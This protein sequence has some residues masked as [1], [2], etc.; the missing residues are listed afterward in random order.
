MGVAVRGRTRRRFWRRGLHLQDEKELGVPEL[1]EPDSLWLTPTDSRCHGC[2]GEWG[3]LL[4]FLSRGQ[5][6]APA[7]LRGHRPG[8]A[9]DSNRES[10]LP[11]LPVPALRNGGLCTCRAG[12]IFGVS[13]ARLETIRTSAWRR[14][15]SLW[16]AILRPSDALN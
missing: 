12:H 1:Q 15:S 7:I 6:Y 5:G 3:K 13:R 14:L 4:Q 16:M 8:L 10:A 2:M 9:S 11:W